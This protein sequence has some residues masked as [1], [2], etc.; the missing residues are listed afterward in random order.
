MQTATRLSVGFLLSFLAGVDCGGEANGTGMGGTDAG[1]TDAAGAD[2][3]GADAG[4]GAGA[5]ASGHIVDCEGLDGS[6]DLALAYAETQ[7]FEKYATRFTLGLTSTQEGCEATLTPE[8]YPTSR[9]LAT[10]EEG[11]VILG[12]TPVSG[13][14]FPSA[15]LA[16]GWYWGLTFFQEYYWHQVVLPRKSNNIGSTATARVTFAYS[17]DDISSSSLLDYA[18]VV[19]PDERLPTVAVGAANLVIPT[20]P[21]EFLSASGGERRPGLPDALLPWDILE[22]RSS[23]P[24]SGLG[25]KVSSDLITWIPVQTEAPVD[26]KDTWIWGRF[27][28]WDQVNGSTQTVT[29]ASGLADRAGHALP[30]QTLSVEVLHVAE[31]ITE[32]DFNGE[33]SVTAFGTVTQG[34]GF[35]TATAPCNSG[36]G[37]IAGRLATA[38]QRKFLAR[39]APRNAVLVTVTGRSGREY[40]T[41][42]S[43]TDA[44]GYITVEAAIDNEPEVGFTIVPNSMCHWTYQTTVDIDR[45][46]AE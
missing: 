18:G 30:E 44:E 35:W 40:Q 32:H 6:Y 14:V 37:G 41:T 10:M 19:G 8:F 34:D 29:V 22:V 36:V 27:V 38:G 43:V 3:G 9:T 17:E 24:L 26:T 15:L 25:S 7:D 42:A 46:W 20:R 39:V 1:G 31:P 23:E 45:V 4:G 11:A 33:L 28:D 5:G 12:E 2:A 13:G 21:P 16:T